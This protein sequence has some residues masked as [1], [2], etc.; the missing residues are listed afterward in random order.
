[1]VEIRPE[2]Y[3]PI[4]ALLSRTRRRA[5]GVS[6]LTGACLLLAATAVLGAVASAVLGLVPPETA[7]RLGWLRSGTVALAATLTVALLWRFVLRPLRRLGGDARVARLLEG[8]L[9]E[10]TGLRSAVAFHREAGRHGAELA[11]AHVARVAQ[12]VVR[13]DPKPAIPTRGLRR[14]SLALGGVLALHAALL[15]LW[16]TV[17]TPGYRRLA[18]LDRPLANLTGKTPAG[19]ATLITGDV[20]L[21]YRYPG[22]THLPPRTVTGTGGDITALKGTEVEIRTVADRD[23]KRAALVRGKT[24]LPLKVTGARSLSGKL[25]VDR[26]GTYHFRFL[27]PQGATVAEGAP[28]A[29]TVRPDGYPHVQLSVVGHDED[30]IEVRDQDHLNLSWH[31]SDD[32]GLTELALVYRIQGAKEKRVVLHHPDDRP[33]DEGRT[34]WDLTPLHLG[35]GDRVA[36]FLEAL[37]DDAVSGPK[38]GVSKTRYLKV[39]SAAEHHRKLMAEVDK[40]WEGMIT[41]L[42]DHLATPFAVGP[43]EP[44][45]TVRPK[46]SAARKL[47]AGLGTLVDHMDATLG[48]LGQDR[49]TPRPLLDALMNIRAGVH[50]VDDRSAS[51]LRYFARRLRVRGMADAAFTALVRRSESESVGELEKDVL[52]LE[53]LLD[54]Q[55]MADLMA[56]A[57]EIKQHRRRLS[58]LIDQ[59]KKHPDE[60]TRA[61]IGEEIS[62]I[63]ARIGELMQKM[64]QLARSIN[65]EHLNAQALAQL[66]K[67]K[68]LLGDLDDVQKLLNEGKLD[69]ALKR[70]AQMGT[71][72]DQMLD[73]WQKQQKGFGGQKYREL[74][75]QMMRFSDDLQR[76]KHQQQRLLDASAKLKQT[77]QKALEHKLKDKLDDLVK[78]LSA[79][80]DDARGQL[81]GIPQA[82]FDEP[83]ARFDADLKD[84]AVARLKDVAMLLKARDFQEARTMA[85]KALQQSRNLQGSL[86]ERA[87]EMR[88]LLGAKASGGPADEARRRADA[89]HDKTQDIRDELDKLFPDPRSVFD[90]QDQKRMARMSRDQEQLRRRA[91]SLQQQMQAMS[92]KAPVFSP[93][94]QGDLQQAMQHMGQAG[95]RLAESDARQASGEQK[96]ALDRLGKLQQAMEQAMQQG[97]GGGIPMPM[98]GGGPGGQGMYGMAHEPVKIPDADSFKAPA[99]FRKELMDAMKQGAPKQYQEQVKDYYQELVK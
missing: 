13:L 9:P 15:A 5:L 56:M 59:L 76:V 7:A 17:F 46:L 28:H 57:Q 86:S 39:F 89:A 16:P 27:D 61:Q 11:A 42:A 53:D 74:A 65:D 6:L 88:G 62:R 73:S 87:M 66:T 63:K 3:G 84:S 80:A 49:L 33:R 35:P 94:M 58:D 85:E 68:N 79:E 92:R 26:G 37:D 41:A 81:Q 30:Q 48:K 4:A 96:S 64:A 24:V 29:I 71:Q 36:F 75:A 67:N 40:L 34:A 20:S 44:E 50:H 12:G 38:K 78:K 54:Q 82:A 93:G 18:G 51:A 55:K 43:D 99:A 90:R 32:F 45:G 10:T 1:M 69:E 2:D 77:Y 8:A 25:V 97:G 22:Y 21:T 52:Y 98:S 95:Q 60:A 19:V 70:L 31:A 14:A 91:A 23:V 83:F 47:E 72:L